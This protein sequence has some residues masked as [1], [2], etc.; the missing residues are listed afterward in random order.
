[1]SLEVGQRIKKARA[2]RG[3]TQEALGKLINAHRVTVAKYE[4]EDGLTI[5]SLKRIAEKT[6][7]PIA[8][9]F[10]EDGYRLERDEQRI[11]L[12]PLT[13]VRQK[14]IEAETELQHFEET[15]AR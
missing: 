14:L 2:A 10:L 12:T 1:M 6:D 4:V 13:R 11:D 5:D 15:L 9:F 7:F 3:L 8:W